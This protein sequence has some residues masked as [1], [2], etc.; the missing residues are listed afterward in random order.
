MH[1]YFTPKSTSKSTSNFTVTSSPFNQMLGHLPAE[2]SLGPN[3][4]R[5]LVSTC[6][7]GITWS[8]IP[9]QFSRQFPR[10]IPHLHVNPH[11]K[12]DVEFLH[13]CWK[14]Q[15]ELCL[16]HVCC[17]VS[18]GSESRCRLQAPSAAAGAAAVAGGRRVRAG[19]EG[20]SGERRVHSPCYRSRVFVCVCVRER[21]RERERE[22][23][24]E[25]GGRE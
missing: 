14:K 17:A 1:L 15:E 5:T 22:R 3:P 4:Q 16:S 2:V 21:E 9:R 13:I 8:Q 19:A 10:Q 7:D 24:K 12:F 23:K 18:A 6:T 25:R 20:G 11:I